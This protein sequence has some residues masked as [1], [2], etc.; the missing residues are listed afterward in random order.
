MSAIRNFFL[1]LTK[2]QG[3]WL[4]VAL[5]LT[6]I[7]YYF[8]PIVFHP[9]EY[10]FS[11]GGDATKNYYAAAYYAKY[12]SGLRFTGM[13]YP[14]DEHILFTDG[15]FPISW[16]MQLMQRA[17]LNV[18][19]Y[20]VP[21][22]NYAL[23]LS[24]VVAAVFLFLLLYE[25]GV[26]A[27]FAIVAGTGIALLSPQLQRFLGHFSL[28]YICY[29]PIVLYC[30]F[31]QTRSTKPFKWSLISIVA[32]LFFGLLHS[33]LIAISA[34]FLLSFGFVFLIVQRVQHR[35]DW[36]QLAAIVFSALTPVILI[37][38]FIALTD[39]YA[40]ER[41]KVPWGFDAF[42]ATWRSVFLPPGWN[43]FNFFE[44]PGNGE[45]YGYI[46]VV[47]WIGLIVFVIVELLHFRD[48]NEKRF[49]FFSTNP[50]LITTLFAS[51]I[52]LLYAMQYPWRFGM[53]AVADDVPLINQFR[54]L[55]RFSWPFYYA[56]GIFAVCVLDKMLRT[57][58]FLQRSWLRYITYV[59]LTALLF[60]DAQSNVKPLKQ[61]QQWSRVAQDFWPDDEMKRAIEK[62]GHNISDFQAVMELPFHHIGT[63]KFWI[64][65]RY[66]SERAV[67]VSYNTGLRM[68]NCQ[69]ARTPIFQSANVIQLTSSSHIEKVLLKQL[70][71]NGKPI[72]LVVSDENLR[73]N[74][75][76]IV[77]KAKQ[78]ASND[79]VRFYS[80]SLDSLV[81]DL[82]L[83]RQNF[84]VVKQSLQHSDGFLT[85]NVDDVI[86]YV[87]IS[88]S[89]EN[90]LSK[91]QY[92]DSG[93]VQLFHQGVNA[94]WLDT[95]G[96]TVSC[97]FK[98]IPETWGFPEVHITHFKSGAEV[99]HWQQTANQSHDIYNGWARF[100]AILPQ[101]DVDSISV[102]V[103]GRKY[104]LASFLMQRTGSDV[105]TNVNDERFVYNNYFVPSDR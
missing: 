60:F 38:L 95:N 98:I 76:A 55:G 92:V 84:N 59:L 96:V 44:Q 91:G 51:F 86:A 93:K 53:R 54:S 39:P 104:E 1:H 75:K 66:S 94:A 78:F 71:Q 2:A 42:Y 19:D 99:E 83:L 25:L 82:D 90:F 49:S 13:N 20:T 50:F 56:A 33:Y 11:I 77:A 37:Q 22:I 100:E 65:G 103:I 97:W 62:S 31:R 23:L 28:G 52:V 34:A 41:V 40:S 102:F 45:G 8:W 5:M 30:L 70:K 85:K 15:S 68:I 21:V 64:E 14:Y 29:L 67:E 24:L 9:L 10:W 46:G 48:N 87:P 63:E 12:D 79:K 3:A 58:Y 81:P 6:L 69:M 26:A 47:A 57:N 88:S 89:N 7:C 72:L 36:K 80:L 18:A 101:R 61:F 73:P 74:D 43:H 16:I 27:A 4:T 32:G 105:Y 35:F 17:G